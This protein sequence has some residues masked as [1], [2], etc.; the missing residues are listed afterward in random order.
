MNK[1]CTPAVK[2]DMGEKTLTVL[3]ETIDA[4]AAWFDVVDVMT[5]PTIVPNDVSTALSP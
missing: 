2:P 3:L 4:K 5:I 1:T